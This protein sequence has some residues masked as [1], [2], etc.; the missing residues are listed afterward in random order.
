MFKL[1]T[2]K[3]GYT[4]VELIIV[5]LLLTLGSVALM[6]L[7]SVAYR[8]YE[9][10]E[11]RFIKQE[12]VKEVAALLQTGTTSVAAAK[13]ADIFGTPEVVPAGQQKDDSYSYLFA[14]ESYND[15]GVFECYYLFVQNKG[16]PRENAIKLSE[17]PIYVEINPYYETRSKLD[18][19][20]NPVPYVVQY[21]AVTITLSALENDY[22]FNQGPPESDDKYYSIDV[23]Y[24]FPNMAT[25]VDYCMV[26][27]VTES[28]LATAS[29]Y[30]QVDN[31]STG[32]K[33]GA[34]VEAVQCT[35][36]NCNSCEC[37][38]N[39][40]D[41]T[42]NINDCGCPYKSGVVLRVYCDS[43]ISP[44]N[45]EA[46]VSVP[47]M[48]F[49]ATASYGLDSGEVGALCAFRDDCLENSALGRAF[50]KAYYTVSPPIADF[51]SESEPLKAVVRTAL[52]PVVV[53]A[54]YALDDS[55]RAEGIVSLAVIMLS[56]AC[57]TAL[58]M[59]LE[60]GFKKAKRSK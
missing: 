31:T 26:N 14:E 33:T 36:A 13:T 42:C 28:Q 58:L 29:L 8:S 34:S 43:I 30:S 53:V 38:S 52:K 57:A 23:A 48:C 41:K 55:I 35:A 10:S 19:H 16:Q 47:S 3:K 9:K 54:Q 18:E 27:H 32:G 20:N 5:L 24:H 46:A 60:K 2:S 40:T 7:I 44:D 45:T 15:D 59:K 1:L 49:I 4:L 50:I 11:E 25:S 39:A 6:N 21:N 12:A 17:T 56:G 51:I 37:S 22:D